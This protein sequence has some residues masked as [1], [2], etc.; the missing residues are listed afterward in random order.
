MF[1]SVPFRYGAFC[2]VP[3]RS[4]LLCSSLL[5]SVLPQ[6]ISI[7]KIWNGQDV[8]FGGFCQFVTSFLQFLRI[9]FRNTPGI[10]KTIFVV[11]KI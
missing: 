9:F 2:F 8:L 11:P 10:L 7:L 6:Y 4:V 3:F 1:D 5:F